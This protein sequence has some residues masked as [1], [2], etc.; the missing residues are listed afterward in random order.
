MREVGGTS[1]LPKI[2]AR[3][4]P[5]PS[6]IKE[7]DDGLM[8][9]SP[10]PYSQGS[11]RSV[12]LNIVDRVEFLT[13]SG[14]RELL[15]E[16]QKLAEEC[17][18]EWYKLSLVLNKRF[19]KRYDPGAVRFAA[20]VVQARSAA[21]SYGEWTKEG[22]FT[23]TGV[24]QSTH[25]EI[26]RY[27]AHSFS[28]SRHVIE[29]CGGLGFD[30]AALARVCSKVTTLEADPE[31]AAMLAYNLA[32]QGIHNVEVINQRMED[33]GSLERFD[34][35]WC[36]PSRRN[37]KGERIKDVDLYSPSLSTLLQAIPPAL[38]LGIKVAPGAQV[39]E[40]LEREWIGWGH[41]C[42]EQVL[43]RGIGKPSYL[44]TLV[45]KGVKWSPGYRTEEFEYEY[46]QNVQYI[47]EPH[48]AIIASGTLS[49][50]FIE[51]DL[52]PIDPKIAY[53]VSDEEPRESP[54]YT[55]F[56][57]LSVLPANLRQLSTLLMEMQWGKE[58]EIKKRGYPEEPDQIR[59]RLKFVESKERGVLFFTRQGTKKIVV[60]ATRM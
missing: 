8:R 15:S 16:I 54:F 40:E 27:H 23:I 18:F 11:P 36:D 38:P 17:R 53:G 10:L 46:P 20:D 13:S 28:G 55:R 14:G 45:D 59:K 3:I 42:R 22:F 35:A 30:T 51:N 34:A 21:A 19:G 50:F 56:R 57:V 39:L 26:A 12:E 32:L 37:E 52:A 9:T 25:P 24:Q 47:V 48:N 29:V 6:F 33:F 41:E 58:T 4:S 49:Q 7:S 31:V 1:P 60:V 5:P 44:V 2:R 43:W